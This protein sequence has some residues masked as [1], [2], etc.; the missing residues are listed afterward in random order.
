MSLRKGLDGPFVMTCYQCDT[1][2]QVLGDENSEYGEVAVR[3]YIQIN[4]MRCQYMPEDK[5]KPYCSVH[6]IKVLHWYCEKCEMT[7]CQD[8]REIDHADHDDKVT[9]N[10][11]SVNMISR[12]LT[13]GLE[14]KLFMT[15]LVIQKMKI[16]N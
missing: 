1:I 3:N 11:L 15:A 10:P 9:E 13:K 2:Q 6:P 16:I 4:Y 7:I 12:Y 14:H 8:C 5:F